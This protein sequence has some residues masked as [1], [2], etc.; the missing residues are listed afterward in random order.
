MSEDRL[1]RMIVIWRNMANDE[2][3]PEANATT[4]RWCADEL[5]EVITD[6]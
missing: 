2:R 6:E 5:E 3:T 1:Q 4:L